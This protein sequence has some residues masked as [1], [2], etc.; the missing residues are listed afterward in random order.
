M[1]KQTLQKLKKLAQKGAHNAYSPYSKIKVGAAVLTEDNK[2][3]FGGNM[4][5]ISFGATVCAERVAILKALSEGHR[6]FTALYLYTKD[7]WTPC[8]MCL[9]VMSEFLSP[10]TPVILGS[11]DKPDLVTTFEKLMPRQ[12]DLKTFKKLQE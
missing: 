4:E 5:N 10:T 9:Q 6:K 11:L 3:Y 8:G 12:V 7:Q 1:N 2:I